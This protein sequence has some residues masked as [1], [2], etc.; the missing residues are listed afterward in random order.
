MTVSQAEARRRSRV[1][2]RRQDDRQGAARRVDDRGPITERHD[3][4]RRRSISLERGGRRPDLREPD[5]ARMNECR[6]RRSGHR[7]PAPGRPPR[8]SRARRGRRGRREAIGV[9]L[10]TAPG[11]RPMRPE[12]GCGI[13][14]YVFDA[15]DALRVGR[16][17]ATTIR[18]ALDRWEPRIDVLDVEVDLSD[19]ET[20]RA[21]DRHHLRAARDQRRAQPRLPVLRHPGRGAA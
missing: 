14:D 2:E 15:I 12:F 21:A 11:E 13:H 10:G 7:L 4:G 17:R 6:H 16:H 8:R 1:E 3:Q 18:D 19:A 5:H 9:I 20:R